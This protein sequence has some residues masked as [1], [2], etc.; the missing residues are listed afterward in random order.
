MQN[1][2]FSATALKGLCH[3]I[4]TWSK[5]PTK[6][7]MLKT[8]TLKYVS[9]NASSRPNPTHFSF[10]FSSFSLPLPSR[11]TPNFPFSF[12]AFL[13]SS[14]FS[15]FLTPKVNS[16][17]FFTPRQLPKLIPPLSKFQQSS[18]QQSLSSK[19][20]YSKF[21]ITSCEFLLLVFDIVRFNGNSC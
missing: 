15:N 1:R 12:L 16:L 7:R 6:N 19:F 9:H 8:T 17:I 18:S 21:F 3:G 5:K 4:E 20:F 2:M 10:I 13:L 14:Y 11:T